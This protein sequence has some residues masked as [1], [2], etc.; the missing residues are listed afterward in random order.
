MIIYTTANIKKVNPKKIS[1]ILNYCGENCLA[2]VD[3][4]FN[5]T[6]EEITDL[7]I[8]FWY[9]LGQGYIDATEYDI[10]KKWDGGLI[11]GIENVMDLSKERNIAMSIR[12][13]ANYNYI[14]PFELW[15]LAIKK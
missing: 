5:M 8:D 11:E 12:E 1:S 15:E 14:D 10:K 4:D 9:E 7:G 6:L 2:E 3:D 13:I